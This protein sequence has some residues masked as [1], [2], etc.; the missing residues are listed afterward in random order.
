MSSSSPPDISIGYKLESEALATFFAA[1]LAVGLRLYCRA[2]YAKIWFED[3]LM[4][5]ALILA[6]LATVM[7]LVAIDRGLGHHIIYL[8]AW[9]RQQQSITGIIAI[10]RTTQTAISIYASGPNDSSYGSIQPLI[11]AS[12]ERNVAIMA[13][14]LPLARPLLRP[15]LRLTGL[16]LSRSRVNKYPAEPGNGEELKLTNV[17]PK[18]SKPNLVEQQVEYAGKRLPS[19]EDNACGTG[20]VTSELLRAI[21]S[22]RIYAVDA[23]AEMV[24]MVRAQVLAEGNEVWKRRVVEVEVMDGHELG[25][26]DAHFDASVM[27]FGILF[28]ADPVRALREMWRTLKASSSSTSTGP[29]GT[30]AGT[31]MGMSVAVVSCW[32]EIGF[33]PILWAVKR[34][35]QPVEEVLEL[36]LLDRWMDGQLLVSVA[37][38][39]G[40]TD[41]KIETLT[42]VLWGKERAELEG[43]LVEN[44]RNLVG[45]TWTDAKKERLAS[46]TREVL[47]ESGMSLCILDEDR[48]GVE[49]SAWVLVARKR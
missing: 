19:E 39:A 40:F 9:Q 10:V 3:Y 44:F 14:N 16:G 27:N 6:L 18:K 34:K 1:G 13:V 33:L 37:R 15:L 49:M 30:G 36:P 7:E 8:D 12:L 22:A 24:S 47:D 31:G 17:K 41:L 45:S 20:A 4:L 28:F 46:A 29:M 2:K 5:F 35:V 21:P 23:S 38:E 11:W 32:K 26:E 43:I 42:E 25:F 48:L